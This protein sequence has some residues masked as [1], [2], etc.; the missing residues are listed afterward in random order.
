MADLAHWF[1]ND[2]S[3]GPTGD[4][5]TVSEPTRTE[6]AIVRRLLTTP[7]DYIWQII[8][9]GGLRQYVGRQSVPILIQNVI[10]GQIFLEQSVSPAPQPTISVQASGTGAVV[11]IGYFNSATQKSS[12]LTFPL[13]GTP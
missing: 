1:G 7:N 2:L 9:G 3:L 11:S 12:L 5:L 10:R 8:Y 13:P 4:L 6:Q